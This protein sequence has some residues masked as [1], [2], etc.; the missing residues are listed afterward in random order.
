[1]GEPNAIA[2]DVE[3]ASP[4]SLLDA[5]AFDR[6]FPQERECRLCEGG[7]RE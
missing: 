7:D 5:V 1:M 4:N 2:V 6:G 3:H